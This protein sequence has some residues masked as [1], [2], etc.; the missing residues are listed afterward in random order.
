MKVI[1]AVTWVVSSLVG[2][3]LIG[4]GL[5]YALPGFDLYTVRSNS[6]R[7]A[8]AAGDVIIVA[9][10]GFMEHELAPGQIITFQQDNKIVSHRII[11]ASVDG[12]TTQGDANNSLDS[13]PVLPAQVKGVF[14]FSIPNLGY[15]AA[16]VGTRQGWFLTIVVPG[17]LLVLWLAADI[18]KETLKLGKDETSEPDV[19]PLFLDEKKRFGLFR[20]RER[21]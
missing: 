1:K 19:R 4:L 20:Q 2:L 16:F 15:V 8:F 3:V 17:M 21:L 7:P 13:A 10:A 9:P 6:M 18:V 11:A 5:V 12:L 14:L